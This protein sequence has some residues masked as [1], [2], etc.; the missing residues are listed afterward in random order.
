[1][2]QAHIRLFVDHPEAI[3]VKEGMT[4][5]PMKFDAEVLSALNPGAN[6]RGLYKVR[7]AQP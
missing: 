2:G 4:P 3:P 5:V 6:R 1:M 7:N